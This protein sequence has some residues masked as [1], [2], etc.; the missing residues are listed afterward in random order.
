[1]R[2]GNSLQDHIRRPYTKF[3]NPGIFEAGGTP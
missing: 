2:V 3:S 1:M